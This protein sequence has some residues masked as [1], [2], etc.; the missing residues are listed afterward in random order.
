MTTKCGAQLVKDGKVVATCQKPPHKIYP[1]GRHWDY[2]QHKVSF[3]W[4]EAA[5]KLAVG[6]Q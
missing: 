5:G 6:S 2:S 4:T 1:A 3:D